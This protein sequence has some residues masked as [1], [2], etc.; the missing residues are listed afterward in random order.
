MC[1]EEAP[2]STLRQAMT[3]QAL[4]DGKLLTTLSGG[5]VVAQEM[6]YHPTCLAGLY[7]RERAV[8]TKNEQS[9]VNDV[10]PL[11]FS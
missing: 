1:E 10:N 11:A 4:N 3:M 2:A 9:H 6:K 8:T 7:N 5:D